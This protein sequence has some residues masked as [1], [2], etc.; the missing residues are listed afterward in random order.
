MQIFSSGLALV[1]SEQQAQL[2][3]P[4]RLLHLDAGKKLLHFVPFQVLYAK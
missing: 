2:H 1:G 4:I 3:P